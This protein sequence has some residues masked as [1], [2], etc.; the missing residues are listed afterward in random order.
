LVS[1]QAPRRPRYA[2]F[3][4][5]LDVDPQ[6]QV[7]GLV[8]VNA[9][10]QPGPPAL[11]KLDKPGVVRGWRAAEDGCERVGELRLRGQQLLSIDFHER[12]G[13]LLQATGF[14]RVLITPDGS[15]LL[16]KPEPDRPDWASIL[17][18]QALPLTATLRGFEVFHAAGVLTRAGAVLLTG[19]P[20][21][22]KSSL[23]AALVRRGA[24]LLSD[25]VVALEYRHEVHPPNGDTGSLVAHPGPAVLNLRPAEQTRL[26][27]HEQALLG[28]ASTV[29]G[30]RRYA[31]T[32]RAHAA[33][34]AGFFV[35]ERSSE[36]PSI[37][38]MEA[39]D[40]ITLIAANFN[41]FV[42]DP[43]RLERNLDLV[44]HL[45]ASGR[46]YRLRIQPEVD[47]TQLA[48]A[49]QEHLAETSR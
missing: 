38:R 44:G 1:K 7:P 34:L 13:Y 42:R 36:G 4:L 33:P 28:P 47:A 22:G 15:E 31:P 26:S 6:I 19:P 43:E 39:V 29:G 18:A 12:A 32:R 23:A 17:S 37:E 46:I 35:L 11:I 40:P 45:A 8:A 2:A 14:G 5:S 16:C 49:L 10:D 20:G 41:A 30:K 27:E 48:A 9:D 3:G 25:D 21:A 24:A